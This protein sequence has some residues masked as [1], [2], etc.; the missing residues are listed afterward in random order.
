MPHASVGSN[1]TRRPGTRL[2]RLHEATPV[3]RGSLMQAAER[4]AGTQGRGRSHPTGALGSLGTETGQQNRGERTPATLRIMDD[5]RIFQDA[6]VHSHWRFPHSHRRDYDGHEYLSKPV[7]PKPGEMMHNI[8]PRWAKSNGQSG[9]RRNS[10]LRRF[11]QMAQ[12]RFDCI[13]DLIQ[14]VEDL[15]AYIVCANVP[16]D[17]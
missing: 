9:P 16:P 8:T 13:H 17:G 15:I 7:K 2:R 11:M 5:R 4:H 6:R 1:P 3:L 10:E 14:G 12:T